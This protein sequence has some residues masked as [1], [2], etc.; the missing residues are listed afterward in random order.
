MT[1]KPSAFWEIAP[2]GQALIRGQTWL[3]GQIFLLTTI[4]VLVF[5][6]KF[7]ITLLFDKTDFIYLCI[8]KTEQQKEFV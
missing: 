6:C 4:M 1:G 5:C 8:D 2:T 7:R 3:W